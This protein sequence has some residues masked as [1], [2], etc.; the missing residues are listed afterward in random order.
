M[1]KF[2]FCCLLVLNLLLFA[3]GR[4][5]LG[6]MGGDVHEAARLKNQLNA[7]KISLISAA[8]ANAAATDGA[9][10]AAAQ[11][12]PAPRDTIVACTEVGNFAA[13]DA[14]RFETQLEA[15]QLGDRQSRH[16]AAGQDI[17][18]YI[19]LIPPQGSKDNADR[20]AAEL[21]QLGVSNYFIISDGSPLRWAISL[22]VFK[23][24]AAAQSQ[25]AALVK[26]GVHSARVNPRYSPSKEFAYQFRDLD[27][28]TR[29]RLEQIRT[30]FADAEIHSCK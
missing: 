22:G 15:L 2:L 9:T 11:S 18:S 3:L 13:A 5:Y 10:A 1:L 26:Q 14:R 29:Q 28:A 6:S 12:P 19:V 16:N 20:K 24:E 21:K 30:G 27:G 8:R 25:L 7:D 4:G 17:S 23:T